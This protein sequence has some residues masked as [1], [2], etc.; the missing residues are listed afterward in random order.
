MIKKNILVFPCGSEIGLEIYR[1]LKG[2][3]YFNLYGAS[4]VKDHG[5]FVYENYIDKIPFIEADD[6]I[7]VINEIVDK[8]KID[9]IF[10]A[11]DSV[12]LKL[13]QNQ[14]ILHCQILGSCLKTSEIARSKLKTYQYLAKYIMVPKIYSKDHIPNFP[15]FLKPDVGQGSKGCLKANSL[16]EVINALQKDKDLLILE[17]LPGKEYTIDCFTDYNHKLIYVQGRQRARIQNGISVNSFPVDDIRFNKIAEIINQVLNFRGAWFFQVKENINNE[18][19]LLEIAP[20]IAGTMELNR[21]QGVNLPLMWCFAASGYGI[22]ILKN[23]YTLQ[24]DRALES[25]FK[26]D[27]IYDYIYVDFDDCIIINNKVNQMLVAFLY[28]SINENKK[29]ILITKH[30]N[31]IE[32]SIKQFR[33]TDIFDQI[34]HIKEDDEKYKY[35]LNNSAIFI[36]DSFSERLRV[37]ENKNIPVF[38]PDMIEGLL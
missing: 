10:P 19:V 17:Y 30:K 7:K 9:F 34:I 28:K 11:H 14:E 13:A 4:S 8:Y 23:N 29:I 3:T 38:S 33:L 16:Q 25:K 12:V 37:Y 31:G 20:R 18:L 2:S 5:M 27:I 1:S 15:V 32:K 36:D 22:K 24:I 6:F 26:I 35:I 21:L